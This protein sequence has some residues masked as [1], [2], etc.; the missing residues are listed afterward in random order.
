MGI[1]DMQRKLEELARPVRDAISPPST[2]EQ[3][4]R[5]VVDAWHKDVKPLGKGLTGEVK[6][7]WHEAEKGFDAFAR[8]TGSCTKEA[9]HDLRSSVEAIGGSSGIMKS[10]SN[11]FESAG[12]LVSSVSK[13]AFE[14][15]QSALSAL[16]HAIEPKQRTK[17]GSR[18]R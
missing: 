13:Q 15:F 6:K 16:C 10:L 12:N 3:A 11:F 4:R 7:A 2:S 9:L 1:S 8:N 5:V 17:G 18:H 14:A